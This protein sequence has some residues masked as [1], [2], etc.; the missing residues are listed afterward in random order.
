LPV[1][2]SGAWKKPVLFERKLVDGYRGNAVGGRKRERRRKGER[3]DLLPIIAK[4][5]VVQGEAFF[6]RRT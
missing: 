2:P 5:I 1:V 4:R 6:I 3:E